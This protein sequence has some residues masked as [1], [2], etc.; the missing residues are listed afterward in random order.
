[1]QNL[2]ILLLSDPAL[3][4]H[5]FCQFFLS[6]LFLSHGGFE[7]RQHSTNAAT[8]FLCFPPSA[9]LLFFVS[10]SFPLP[11]HRESGFLRNPQKLF[12]VSVPPFLFPPSSFFLPFFLISPRFAPP[13]GFVTAACAAPPPS[14]ASVRVRKVNTSVAF[15]EFGRRSSLIPPLS[16]ALPVCLNETTKECPE[17]CTDTLLFSFLVPRGSAL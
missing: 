4:D 5:F 7:P 11:C 2:T 12:P 10:C 14:L 15:F 3:I 6:K 16:V 8:P 13:Q 9:P 1:M 17:P